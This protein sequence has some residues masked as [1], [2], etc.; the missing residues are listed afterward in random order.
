M[1]EVQDLTFSYSSGQDVFRHFNWKVEA[2]ES[3][4]ILGP[5]GCGKS[6]LLYLIAGL[7]FPAAG[8]VSIDG[9]KIERPRPK[10]GL[11]IQDYGLMPWASVF[12]NASLGLQIRRFYGPDG[13][14]APINEQTDPAQVELWLSRL[15]LNEQRDKYPAQLSG[16]QRQRTAIARTLAIQ[17]DLLLMDEPFSSLDAPTRENLQQLVLDLW[18]EQQLTLIT[19]THSIEEAAVLGQKILLLHEPPNMKVTIIDNPEMNQ[20]HYRDSAAYQA[21]CQ[22]LRGLMHL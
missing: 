18:R 15:G 7:R 8:V 5:S 2:A 10:S 4:V 14:H 6:T 22:Q 11:I 21:V 17:P 1:I 19:V 9:E 16:G 20:K 12:E 13:K 3:W